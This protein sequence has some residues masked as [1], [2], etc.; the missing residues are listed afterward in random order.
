MNRQDEAL[1]QLQQLQRQQPTDVELLRTIVD[2]AEA[3]R[4]LPTAAA[5]QQRLVQ[6]D[7]SPTERERLARLLRQAGQREEALR[8][9]DD[10]LQQDLPESEL[11]PLVDS[12]LQ[13]PDLFQA[14][15]FV[16][17]GLAQSPDNWRLAY[18]SAL[19]H[20]ALKQPAAARAA[21]ESVLGLQP[22]RE[23]PSRNEVARSGELATVIEQDL[24]RTLAAWQQ[25]HDLR[26]QIESSGAS[27]LQ[28]LNRLFRSPMLDAGGDNSLRGTQLYSA[29]G[30]LTWFSPDEDPQP[31]LAEIIQRDDPPLSLLRVATLAAWVTHHGEAYRELLER[32]QRQAPDSA[33][34]HLLRI[35]EPPSVAA[36]LT[37]DDT[38]RLRQLDASLSW[39][40]AHAGH[41]LRGLRD[42]GVAQLIYH[43]NRP[44]VV[45]LS[46]QRLSTAGQLQDL[47]PW[48]PLWRLLADRGTQ[49]ESLQRAARLLT[50]S[51]AP[52]AASD[53]QTWLEF[54][55]SSD[56]L[57]A[58]DPAAAWLKLL[59]AYLSLGAVGSSS[60]AGPTSPVS[61][62]SDRSFA[63]ILSL[64]RRRAQIGLDQ[65]TQR[66]KETGSVAE[67]R[68]GEQ[69]LAQAR[70]QQNVLRGAITGEFFI[71]GQLRRTRPALTGTDGDDRPRAVRFPQAGA[72]LDDAQLNLLQQLCQR[73]SDDGQADSF[74]N[75]LQQ[76]SADAPPAVRPTL[77]MAHIYALA[78]IGESAAALATLSQLDEEL[79]GD[80]RIRLER[81]RLLLEQDRLTDSLQLLSGVRELPEWNS[82]GLVLREALARRF[83]QLALS[84]DC[85]GHT[86][87]V[88]SVAFSPDG[89]TLASASVDGTVR[90]WDVASGRLRANLSG[91][92]N[93]VLAVAFAPRGDRLASSG[94][95]RC[96][97][98]WRTDDWQPAGKLEGHTAAVRC[99]A[100]APDGTQLV[101]GGD[102][103]SI[104]AWDLSQLSKSRELRG[105]RDSVLTLAF[106]PSGHQLA[107]AGSDRTTRIWNWAS[108]E[109]LATLAAP[110]GSSQGLVYLLDDDHLLTGHDQP[111]LDAWQQ[112][113]GNWN[114][115]PLAVFNLPRSLA[116][117]P[118]DNLLAIGCED[119]SVVL[120]DLESGRE[121][122]V[123]RGHTGRVL[124]VAFSPDGQRLASAGF[125]GIVKLWQ[126][127]S[128]AEPASQS[129]PAIPPGS[130]R[131]PP[132]STTQV[133]RS[134]DGLATPARPIPAPAS[135]PGAR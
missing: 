52:T 132:V 85:L 82:Q 130:V 18:R 40:T 56:T 7:H 110:A 48:I 119:H 73:Q 35:V 111:S 104:Y 30:L 67:Q 20:L 115:T 32:L 78:W 62:P 5:Y 47:T 77:Q 96:I 49:L 108:G 11:L 25:W 59:E 87:V 109:I 127:H 106:S 90:I 124:T 21:L 60:M 83:S 107:S 13:R 23:L 38:Q 58:D 101:S 71:D 74:V 39:L 10:L 50:D 44:A 53:L 103:H 26:A 99:L 9:W 55:I 122:M 37:P 121:Q 29:I 100:F 118:T 66:L 129:G 125:D 45:E 41:G 134:S 98:L 16:E 70:Q 105:H 97:R 88:H 61:D 123:L 64:L 19:L 12:L 113:D 94:Y 3:A 2:V 86:G 92:Q 72:F 91:H 42:L 131:L 76:R 112:T 95:D 8:V 57:S 102:D 93:I 63:E 51:P 79:A 31:W 135:A 43:P 126:V 28:S 81:V 6:R 84:R 68:L 46:R 36:S 65:A 4:Q 80:P 27:S 34:P 89:A 54:A 116:F 117:S 24:S 128:I 120:W 17:W 22:A 133:A 1:Q 75:W 114:A 69:Q 33:L 14:Q 15:R